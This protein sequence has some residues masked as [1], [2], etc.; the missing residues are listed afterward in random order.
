[1]RY[2]IKLGLGGKYR[3]LKWRFLTREKAEA[4]VA[5]FYPTRYYRIEEVQS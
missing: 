1:M 5:R 3:A 2:I 4:Y